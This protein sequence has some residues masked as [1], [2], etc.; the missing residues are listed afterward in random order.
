MWAS[1]YRKPFSASSQQAGEDCTHYLVQRSSSITML[2]LF[3]TAA[4]FA[5]F[6]VLNEGKLQNAEVGSPRTWNVQEGNLESRHLMMK[7]SL[8]FLPAGPV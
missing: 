7:P 4:G 8:P 3:E 5:L 1:L 2:V 6:K